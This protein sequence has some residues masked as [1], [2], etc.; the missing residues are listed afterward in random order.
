VGQT[1]HTIRGEKM[2]ALRSKDGYKMYR[3]NGSLE[4]WFGNANDPDNSCRVGY[5]ANADNFEHAVE[6]AKEDAYYL[7]KEY[8]LYG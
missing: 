1:L 2:R 7:M 6:V 5:V 8:E 4:M 3:I